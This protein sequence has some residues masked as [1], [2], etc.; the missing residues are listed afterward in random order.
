MCMQVILPCG[1]TRS[2]YLGCGA[3]LHQLGTCH[4]QESGGIVLEINGQVHILDTWNLYDP[5][6]GAEQGFIS[7]ASMSSLQ[8]PHDVASKIRL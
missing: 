3:R 2:E 8:K 4:G 1:F 5:W 6:K 7:P